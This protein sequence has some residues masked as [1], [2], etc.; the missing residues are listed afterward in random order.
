MAS[1][2]FVAHKRKKNRGERGSR[3]FS[4]EAET[5][6]WDASERKSFD[7]RRSALESKIVAAYG[8]S[9]CVRDDSRLAFNFLTGG[10]DR[11]D[12]TED[13]VVNELAHAQF[14]YSHTNY[15]ELWEK[16]TRALATCIRNKYPLVSWKRTWQLVREHMDPCIK[17]EAVRLTGRVLPPPCDEKAEQDPST[18]HSQCEQ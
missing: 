1:E 18:A 16:D 12:L 5:T 11:A 7:A 17:L 14:L 15:K 9:Y 3:G 6:D 8:A 10:G 4:I 13:H 2:R